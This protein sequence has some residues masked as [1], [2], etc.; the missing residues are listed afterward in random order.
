M[1]DAMKIMYCL[2]VLF[3]GFSHGMEDHKRMII[4]VGPK[5]SGK[6]TLLAAI[7]KTMSDK[8]FIPFIIEKGRM[9]LDKA[10]QIELTN[11]KKEIKTEFQDEYEQMLPVCR[12]IERMLHPTSEKCYY[13]VEFCALGQELRKELSNT[14]QRMR[15][16]VVLVK[17]MCDKHTAQYRFVNKSELIK[18]QLKNSSDKKNTLPKANITQHYNNLDAIYTIGNHS[19]DA[20]VDTTTFTY[21]P[22]LSKKGK[23]R[24]Y[25]EFT[26]S[27]REYVPENKQEITDDYNKAA[28]TIVG[29]LQLPQKEKS[30]DFFFKQQEL[31]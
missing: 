29:L 20:S 15:N 18:N 11:K 19:F 31:K 14:L 27:P 23:E 13:L 30:L 12:D 24:K 22:K 25:E 5:N 1:R 2:L 10:E 9:S 16:L 3:A 6:T 26:N 8:G 21:K 7:K 28:E 4:L 17:V